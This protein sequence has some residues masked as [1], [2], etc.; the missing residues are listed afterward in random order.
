VDPSNTE[1]R[2]G[3]FCTIFPVPKFQVNSI[4]F[5]LC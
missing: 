2:S 4:C 5:C 3:T 1:Y